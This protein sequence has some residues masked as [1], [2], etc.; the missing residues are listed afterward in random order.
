MSPTNAAADVLLLHAAAAAVTG[1]VLLDDEPDSW[2]ADREFATAVEYVIVSV[3]QLVSADTAAGRPRDLL[4]PS[5][6]VRAVVHAPFG[7]H[8]LSYPDRYPADPASSVEGPG[9]RDHW[10]YLDQVG[11]ARLVRRASSNNGRE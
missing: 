5:G 7:S 8:P 3:E 1:D 11:F 10:S 4:I 6:R 2:Y 9:A